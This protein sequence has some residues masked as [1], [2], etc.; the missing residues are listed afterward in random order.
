M[1]AKQLW[2]VI[3]GLILLNCITVAFFLTKAKGANGAGFTGET[4]ATVGDR[5]ITRQ[6]WLSELELRYGQ[7]VLRDMIDQKVIGQMAEKYN[8]KIS[9]Q[10]VDREMKM[11]QAMYSSTHNGQNTSQKKWKEQIKYNL[12][13]EDILTK[14]VVV[15][16]KEVKKYYE[17][18]KDLF[19]VPDSYHL[20]HILVKTKA[21]AKKT[22]KELAG[23]SSFRALAMER[24]IDEFSANQGGDIGYL[25]EEDERYPAK[26]LDEAKKLK[27]G[28]WSSPIKTD[29]GYAIIYLQEKIK[30]QSYTYKEVEGQIKRQIALEQMKEPATAKTFWDEAKVNWFYGEQKKD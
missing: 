18:N 25:N 10:T 6:E 12:L 29:D 11:N 16:E 26:Y 4:V 14:D 24:S 30:G 22:E 8:I 17:R 15:P 28:H 19:N 13:L 9:D 1:K 3:A 23:G 2:L 20:S 5:K 27:K 21:E 7:D